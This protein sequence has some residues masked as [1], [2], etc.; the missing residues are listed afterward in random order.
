MIWNRSRSTAR[1]KQT[2]FIDLVTIN[3]VSTDETQGFQSNAGCRQLWLKCFVLV[4]INRLLTNPWIDVSWEQV[5]QGCVVSAG[6]K[7]A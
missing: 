1:A 2:K 5:K 7:L 4:D 3:V 6:Q